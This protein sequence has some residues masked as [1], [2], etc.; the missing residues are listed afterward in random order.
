[1]EKAHFIQMNKNSFNSA[2]GQ[3]TYFVR[4]VAVCPSL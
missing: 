4:K 2:F 1:M 3:L